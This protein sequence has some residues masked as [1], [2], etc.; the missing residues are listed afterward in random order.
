MPF[1]AAPSLLR[2]TTQP[3]LMMVL[4]M[5]MGNRSPIRFRIL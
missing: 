3:G 2:G 5:N 4:T 1:F